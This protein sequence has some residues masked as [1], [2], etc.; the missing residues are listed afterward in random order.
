MAD[1]STQE[2]ASAFGI[3]P[4]RLS[5]IAKQIDLQPTE[6]TV[7]GRTRFYDRNAV[8]KILAL[9]GVNYPRNK[10]ICVANNKGGV[11]K[12]SIATFLAKRLVAMGF[13]TLLVDTDPQ[14]NSTSYFMGDKPY[15]K[16]LLDCISNG[17]AVEDVVKEVEPGLSILPSSLR[18]SRLEIELL[19]AKQNSGT[20]FKK[21]LQKQ[22][23]NY[24]IMDLS[25]SFS[26]INFMAMVAA[27]MILIP[28]IL[29]KFSIEGVQM[30]L[31]TINDMREI[32]PDAKAEIKCVINQIDVRVSSQL[33]YISALH[34]LG[35]PMFTTT[36][37][38]DVAVNKNQGGIL[39]D[40]SS[41]SGFYED[42][43]KFTNEVVGIQSTDS[44]ELNN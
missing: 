27:D 9:R 6:S 35:V 11:G 33:A 34:E 17:T 42:I 25:P 29:T 28:T 41:K 10:I 37:R 16:V 23:V 20:F 13:D 5:I 32:Y 31:D 24:I 39:R 30:T 18:N 8:R 43:C 15:D 44:K 22:N 2:L 38:S 21:L 4:Q 36:L 19:H 1:I 7:K 40:L 3:S 12:T 14:A 26:T